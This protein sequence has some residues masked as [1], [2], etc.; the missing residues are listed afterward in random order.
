M[1]PSLEIENGGAAEQMPAWNPGRV[2]WFDDGAPF[3]ADHA[4]A[5]GEQDPVI[6]ACAIMIIDHEILADQ[7][8]AFT[9]VQPDVQRWAESA[10]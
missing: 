3:G 5:I 10:L 7:E 4:S 8:K 2:N 1:Q 9:V 6:G